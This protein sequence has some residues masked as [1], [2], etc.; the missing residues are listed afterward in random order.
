MKN[1][2][3]RVVFSTLFSVFHLVIKHCVSCL[4]YYIEYA[5]ARKMLNLQTNSSFNTIWLFSFLVFLLFFTEG[6][7]W[8][9]CKKHCARII[10]LW[11]L[12]TVISL[13]T[14]GLRSAL[15][16]WRCERNMICRGSPE[17]F[18]L[19]LNHL[20]CSQALPTLMR[21]RCHRKRI[22]PSI[23]VPPTVLM[24]FRV[25]TLKRSKTIVLHV[26]T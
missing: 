16:R 19:L 25:S 10:L 24:R 3:L 21:F 6:E 23:P 18:M 1:T 7:E 26:V 4:I 5:L 9:V 15:Q 14:C 17:P 2:P 20:P 8:Y 11:Y 13:L 12:S 22:A